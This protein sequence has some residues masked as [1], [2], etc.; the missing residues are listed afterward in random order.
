MAYFDKIKKSEQTTIK[1]KINWRPVIPA[2]VGEPDFPK[3]FVKGSVPKTGDP[4]LY[5]YRNEEGKTCF[6]ITRVEKDRQQ[7]M[8][9]PMSLFERSDNGSFQ[10]RPNAWAENRPLFREELV[11]RS[12]KPVLILEGEKAVK[13]AESIPFINDK[14]IGMLSQLKEL[15]KN[16]KLYKDEEKEETEF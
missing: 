1:T 8:F 3:S 14:Y 4:N 11:N 13:F 9:L 7:K 12:D 6:Y 16:G 15:Q 5:T 10:W 2:D